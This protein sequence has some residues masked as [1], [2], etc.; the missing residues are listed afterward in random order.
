MFV[1]Y[2]DLMVDVLISCFFFGISFIKDN[3][4]PVAIRGAKQS[5]EIVHRN[6]LERSRYKGG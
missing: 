1:T 3:Y 2:V 4:K 5:S 6:K